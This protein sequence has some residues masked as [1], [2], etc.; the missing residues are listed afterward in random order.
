MKRTVTVLLVLWVGVFT[1]V[2][3][4]AE[5]SPQQLLTALG[6]TT[7]SGY[8]SI[9]AHWGT[10]S[11]RLPRYYR[12]FPKVHVT[13]PRFVREAT[14]PLSGVPRVFRFVVHRIGAKAN[15]TTV[16]LN[17]SSEGVLLAQGGV[18]I[19]AGASRATCSWSVPDNGF[20]DGRRPFTAAISL[21]AVRAELP[22]A[23]YRTTS[24][25]PRRATVVILDPAA[26]R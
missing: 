4:H 9:S 5:E 24:R 2:S 15:E 21:D 14:D 7:I 26:S 13:G 20:H 11:E 10:S 3:T 17:F 22:A 16:Y 23:Q 8:V 12:K 19:P 1:A 6:S 18:T 25:K